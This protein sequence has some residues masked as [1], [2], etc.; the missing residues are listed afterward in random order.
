MMPLSCC[1]SACDPPPGPACASAPRARQPAAA[2]VHGRW[3]QRRETG[4][5]AKRFVPPTLAD[6]AAA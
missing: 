4:E 6:Q 2:R 5:R 3:Q 1:V